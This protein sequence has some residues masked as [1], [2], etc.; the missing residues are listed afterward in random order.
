MWTSTRRVSIARLAALGV[1][2]P[3]SFMTPEHIQR[4][5]GFGCELP[6]GSLTRAELC[7]AGLTPPSA[8]LLD[9][10]ELATFADEVEAFAR[11][12]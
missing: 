7:D 10:D 2:V 11:R 1:A 4:C 3:E 5:A 8:E 9:V 6:A 12:A